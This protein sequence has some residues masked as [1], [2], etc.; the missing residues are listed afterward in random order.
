MF[1]KQLFFENNKLFDLTL[2]IIFLLWCITISVFKVN[3]SS[4]TPFFYFQS[5]PIFYWIGI[6]FSVYLIIIL[7]SN[8]SKIHPI[9]VYFFIFLICLYLYGITPFTY[10]NPI[11]MDVYGYLENLKTIDT[12]GN[13]NHA[14]S[15]YKIYPLA[16]L[17]HLSLIDI[18]NVNPIILAKFNPIIN[19][20]IGSTFIYSI[21]NIIIKRLAFMPPIIYLLNSWIPV[22]YMVPQS[23]GLLITMLFIF[24]ISLRFLK[25][26]NTK[27]SITYVL[28][29]I[30]TMFILILSHPTTAIINIIAISSMFIFYA[31]ILIFNNRS[32]SYLKSLIS[33]VNISLLFITTYLGYILF[34][35]EFIFTLFVHMI[36]DMIISIYA[37]ESLFTS[38]DWTSTTPMF[39]YVISTRLRILNLII[40]QIG[41]FFVL[42]KLFQKCKFRELK[43]LILNGLFL[44]YSV[45]TFSTVASRQTTFVDRGFVFLI[46]PFSFLI[47]IY[48]NIEKNNKVKYL[49]NT[50]TCVIIILNLMIN[51]ILFGSSYSYQYYSESEFMGKHFIES[52]NELKKIINFDFYGSPYV[53]FNFWYNYISIHHKKGDLYQ[54]Q[55]YTNNL[56]KIYDTKSCIVYYPID[57]N[58]EEKMEY[59]KLT[60]YRG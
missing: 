37:Q 24:L 57:K 12:Y 42:L 34:N 53:F 48:I 46:M 21:S 1:T 50:F 25:F 14:G 52:H 5:L 13:L 6:I 20:F 3:I 16:P 28:L 51:P 23:Y 9:R 44:G 11:H 43:I 59:W 36:K 26:S 2:S 49:F 38:I 40:I 55:F 30:L 33:F 47:P 35:S 56:C 31:L 39:E 10:P 32:I 27:N 29:L 45:I 8:C 58:L 15:Y 54:N 17:Y 22:H 60:D 18:V 41:G 19:V 7:F 4:P